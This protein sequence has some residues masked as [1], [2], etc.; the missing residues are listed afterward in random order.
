MKINI[1]EQV[2]FI[3]W[4]NPGFDPDGRLQKNKLRK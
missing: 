3:F 1:Y 2:N 4:R